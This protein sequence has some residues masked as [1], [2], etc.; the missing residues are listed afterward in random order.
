VFT[1]VP[2]VRVAGQK[3][4]P[5]TAEVFCGCPSRV[6]VSQKIRPTTA[7]VYKRIVFVQL[8]F[9]MYNKALVTILPG[10]FRFISSRL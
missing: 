4:R 9:S 5:A 6:V 7:E 10:E 3:I 1:Q 8:S 2:G